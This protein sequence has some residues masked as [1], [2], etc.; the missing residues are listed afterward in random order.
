[1]VQV[2]RLNI[3]AH[4]AHY[5]TPE[6]IDEVSRAYPVVGHFL[7]NPSLT[8][9][10]DWVYSQIKK[11][12][13]DRQDTLFSEVFNDALDLA[14]KLL[15]AHSPEPFQYSASKALELMCVGDALPAVLSWRPSSWSIPSEAELSDIER[16]F[17][18]PAG[19][20]Y[21]RDTGPYDSSKYPKLYFSAAAIAVAFLRRLPAS[22]RR[23]MRRIVIDEDR[24]SVSYPEC[25]ARGLIPFCV[26]NPRLRIER[27]IGWYKN[28]F[29]CTWGR[30]DSVAGTRILAMIE[31]WIVEASNLA[32]QG[33]PA[34]S[35]SLIVDG[36][37]H[38]T[39]HIWAMVRGACMIYEAMM[40]W[41]SRNSIGAYIV[42]SERRLRTLSSEILRRQIFCF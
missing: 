14:L 6:I 20:D 39:R 7:H 23:A 21:H 34:H 5:A 11:I 42:N 13:L 18:S 2:A 27:R 15:Q 24:K 36:H 3:L 12:Q 22:Q 26:E 40:A 9:D 10:V 32:R 31:P 25:H 19:D 33:M 8:R 41:R 16:F 30:K 38:K 4:T 35:F 28:L 1:M 29:P 17:R 37:G